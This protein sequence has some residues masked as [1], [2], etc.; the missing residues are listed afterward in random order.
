MVT[1]IIVIGSEAAIY[2]MPM[3]AKR[4]T[5]VEGVAIAGLLFTRPLSCSTRYVSLYLPFLT[6]GVMK[7]A[8]CIGYFGGSHV[9]TVG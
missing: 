3:Q 2:D 1:I 7:Q 9:N 5:M 4:R 6:S 8:V